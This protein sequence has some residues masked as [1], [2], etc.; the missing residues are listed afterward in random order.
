MEKKSIICIILNPDI[1]KCL[2]IQRRIELYNLSDSDDFI[3]IIGYSQSK[4]DAQRMIREFENNAQKAGNHFFVRLIFTD[5]VV[6]K[7]ENYKKSRKSKT[8][9]IVLSQIRL[10]GGDESVNRQVPHA[11]QFIK[12]FGLVHVLNNEETKKTKMSF[13]EIVLNFVYGKNI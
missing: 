5:L 1:D 10:R 11:T 13:A 12:H 4:R 9:E 3:D 7:K 2:E 8:E 6:F